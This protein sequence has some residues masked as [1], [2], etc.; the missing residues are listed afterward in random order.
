MESVLSNLIRAITAGRVNITQH[1]WQE[2][3]N[4]KL[5]LD[6]VLSATRNGKLIED[7]P[8]DF[9]FPSGLVSGTASENEPI[10]A[11]WAFDN[12]N[13]IAILVTVYRPD[14]DRWVDFETR[15]N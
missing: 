5:S 8:L 6:D 11:V 3:Q 15:R 2:M 10:H 14:P 4:D 13:A 1:A 7:Y 9:P 12:K